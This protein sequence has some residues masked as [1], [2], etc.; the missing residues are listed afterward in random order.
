MLLLT[1]HWCDQNDGLLKY[2]WIAHDG[3][4]FGM[5]DIF[6]TTENS[7]SVR[8]SW[9]KRNGGRHGGDWTTRTS[10]NPYNSEQSPV[11]ASAIFYFITDYT[12]WIRD[13]KKHGDGLTL[14][15][16]TKDVGTFKVKI[17]VTGRNKNENFSNVFVDFTH[18]NASV[19][20]LKETLVQTG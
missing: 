13:L 20:V 9:V 6:E 4:N 5:H 17:E 8:T 7:F 16:E 11:F 19:A 15:G 10:F 2:G 18:G 12:G 1:R 3:R 14:S